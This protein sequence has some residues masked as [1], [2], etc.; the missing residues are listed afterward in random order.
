MLYFDVNMRNFHLLAPVRLLHTTPLLP[1]VYTQL[2]APS[3]LLNTSDELPEVRLAL[4]PLS[5]VGVLDA[6]D[7]AAAGDGC[8]DLLGLRRDE[9]VMDVRAVGGWS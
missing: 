4:N 5:E 3:L 7:L 6:R 9:A 1:S 2:A 8:G